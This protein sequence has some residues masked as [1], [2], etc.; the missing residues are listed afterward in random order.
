M[1]WMLDETAAGLEVEREPQLVQPEA[2]I[3]LGGLLSSDMVVAGK[4]GGLFPVE[5]LP[6]PEQV[7]GRRC[8]SLSWWLG[9][10]G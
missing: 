4:G 6:A 7:L 9:L 1:P 8:I 3:G 2:V 5:C 10:P